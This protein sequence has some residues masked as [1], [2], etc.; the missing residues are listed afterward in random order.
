MFGLRL[1]QRRQHGRI[2]A[3]VLSLFMS[4]GP[5][6]PTWRFKVFGSDLNRPEM[7]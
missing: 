2:R 6:M 1:N 7:L 4:V 5:L 3:P